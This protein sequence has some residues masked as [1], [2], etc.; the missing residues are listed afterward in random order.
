MSKGLH[1]A[2]ALIAILTISTGTTRA[3]AQGIPLSGEKITV[4]AE[5]LPAV[6][7]K[8]GITVDKQS[9]AA[10]VDARQLLVVAD[11]AAAAKLDR[12]ALAK[13]APLSVF[14]VSSPSK[15]LPSGFYSLNVAQDGRRG[16]SA[17]LV[18]FDGNRSVRFPGHLLIAPVGRAAPCRIYIDE[19]MFACFGSA[20][21]MNRILSRM[22]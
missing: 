14:Y 18:S 6:A 5:Q 9:I 22:E 10:T 4:I 17:S 11:V 20:D 8:A 21:F 15:Q 3:G 13:G 19:M 16:W 7:A 2:A 12:A 1:L